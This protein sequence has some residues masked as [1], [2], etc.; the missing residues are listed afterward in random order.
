VP[1]PIDPRCEPDLDTSFEE[2]KEIL[3]REHAVN[4][5]CGARGGFDANVED[6]GD[7]SQRVNVDL[8]CRGCGSVQRHSLPVARIRQ[9]A[10][11]LR[12]V[13]DV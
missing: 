2:L 3:I 9:L 8:I 5:K 4:C 13:M 7:S 10:S 12:P 1:E 6:F 11:E